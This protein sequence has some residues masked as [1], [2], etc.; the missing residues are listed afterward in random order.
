M[1]EDVATVILRFQVEGFENIQ[2]FGVDLVDDTIGLS[3]NPRIGAHVDDVVGIIKGNGRCSVDE[4][5]GTNNVGIVRDIEFDQLSSLWFVQTDIKSCSLDVNS[6]SAS[7][8]T[9]QFEN[10]GDVEGSRAQIDLQHIA[11]KSVGDKVGSVSDGVSDSG[12]DVNKATVLFGEHPSEGVFFG[13][14]HSAS[15]VDPQQSSGVGWEEKLGG[16]VTW[17]GLSGQNCSIKKF[18]VAGLEAVCDGRCHSVRNPEGVTL[19]SKVN[20]LGEGG[21]AWSIEHVSSGERSEVEFDDL[22]SGIGNSK[23]GRSRELSR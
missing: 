17:E 7:K 15:N 22:A 20:G 5:L 2:A 1:K 23:V 12:P 13:A 10:F 9:T 4:S 11:V 6:N 19:R 21:G 14:G 16:A 18:E 8:A 3:E